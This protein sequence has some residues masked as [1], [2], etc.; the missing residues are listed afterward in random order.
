MAATVPVAL[1]STLAPKLIGVDDPRMIDRV[2]IATGGTVVVIAWADRQDL[3]A[4]LRP[5]EAA[6][7]LVARFEHRRLVRP[8]ASGT[9]ESPVGS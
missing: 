6:R 9:R 7:E 3:V 5:I 8:R 2:C 4:R 1:G